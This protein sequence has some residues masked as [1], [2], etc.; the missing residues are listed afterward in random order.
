MIG[1]LREIT[2]MLRPLT[3]CYS[4]LRTDILSVRGI[5]ES[6]RS[7]PFRLVP[8]SVLDS[9]FRALLLQRHGHA[10]PSLSGALCR[11]EA[12]A[13]LFSPLLGI[14]NPLGAMRIVVG[15]IRAVRAL[16]Q[17]GAERWQATFYTGDGGSWHG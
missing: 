9:I 15:T 13:V 2:K 3:S 17:T 12:L 4:T 5:S 16:I 1:L 7:V 14:F 6:C 11:P 10:S 8:I